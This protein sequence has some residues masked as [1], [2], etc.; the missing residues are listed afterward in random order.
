MNAGRLLTAT[1]VPWLLRRWIQRSSVTVLAYHD[2]SPQSFSR[3]IA[4]LRP[5]YN[6]IE[7]SRLATALAEGSFKGL[8]PRA[9]VLTLDDGHR[10]NVELVDIIRR[11]RV[12]V[13]VLVCP[14]LLGGQ[15]WFLQTDPEPLKRI[16]DQIRRVAIASQ[17]D[18]SGPRHA[19]SSAELSLLASVADI[20]CHTATHPVLP[21]CDT[22]VARR[23]IEQS[24]E[25]LQA[26]L[27]HDVYAL[28]YPNGD[29]SDRDIE[30]VRDAGYC[31]GLTTDPGVNRQ[32]ADPLKL[33]RISVGD[34]DDLPTLLAKASGLWAL[35][36]WSVKRRPYGHMTISPASYP[37]TLE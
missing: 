17:A 1:G 4:G 23:E 26:L 2:P 13:T 15:F 37:S 33:R 22:D 9:L 7:L 11:E 28:A 31:V 34:E 30:L 35:I 36:K 24:R 12:P 8:P 21:M 5:R 18:A 27:G 16:P 20:Q 14:E 29:Y 6:F 3:H 25:Q 32:S 10:R 19:L